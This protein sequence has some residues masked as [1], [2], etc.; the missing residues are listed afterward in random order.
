MNYNFSDIAGY[1]QEK[2]ELKRLCEIINNRDVYMERGAKLPKGIIFYGETGTGKTLFAK[3]MAGV[4]NLEMINIDLGSMAD[5][6]AVLKKIKKA[7]DGARKAGKPT[8]I[9][10]DEMDKV[11]PNESED[12]FSDHSK[13]ILAQLLSLIDGMSSNKNFIFVATCNDYEGLPAALVRPGRID[14]RYISGNRTTFL[15]WRYLNFTPKRQAVP[16]E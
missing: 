14:K 7:F 13:A 12:Y 3:V 6:R 15:A 4:C 10:F 2:E 1:A 5:E 9:F 16:L 8:M 11:L